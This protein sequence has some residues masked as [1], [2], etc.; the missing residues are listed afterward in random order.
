MLLARWS[1]TGGQR[2]VGGKGKRIRARWGAW[3]PLG[4][5]KSTPTNFTPTGFMHNRRPSFMLVPA[6]SMLLPLLPPRLLHELLNWALRCA[7]G[8]PPPTRGSPRESHPLVLY[9]PRLGHTLSEEEIDPQH[10]IGKNRI[11]L[12]SHVSNPGGSLPKTLFSVSYNC[13]N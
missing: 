13:E 2:S 9:T 3:A 10:N 4:S 6:P 1:G 8:P 12:H 5:D 7:L 11:C